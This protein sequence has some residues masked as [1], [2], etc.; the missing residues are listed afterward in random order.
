MKAIG[1]YVLLIRLLIIV[2]VSTPGLAQENNWQS[3]FNEKDLTGWQS[4]NGN[5][6]WE[7]RDGII[8]GTTVPGEPNGFLCTEKE[9]GD[10]VLE[11]EVSIDTLMNNSGVQF[12]SLSYPGYKNGRVHGYQV[13]INPLRE[14]S[15]L[16]A[17]YPQ[18]QWNGAIYEEGGNRGWLYP[19]GHLSPRAREA[20]KRDTRDDYQW[21]N[22]RI[23]AIG[24]S[25]RTWING[26][27]AAHLIDDKFH[28][29]FIGLQLHANNANDPQGSFSVRFRNIRIQ[30]GDLT[31]T[32][33]DNTF[34]VNLLP[35]N[36]SSQEEKNGF[37]L[38]WDGRST[39]GW[40]GPNQSNFPENAWSVDGG[41]L[42]VLKTSRTASIG[43]PYII[44]DQQ[45]GPFE[46]KFDFKISKGADSGVKYFVNESE[47]TNSETI[48]ALEYQVADDS[49]SGNIKNLSLGS[50][51]GIMESKKT[52]VAVKTIGEWNQALIKVHPDN[53]VEYWLNG[54]KILQFQR[55]SADFKA[56]VAKSKYKD[57][58]NFGMSTQGHI[59]LENN[60]SQVAYRS[61]K[62]KTLR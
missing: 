12:R 40:L 39:K 26:V 8:V 34:V 57:L 6:I 58:P 1:F 38:L 13:E 46:L 9:Y 37:V 55:G 11:F 29:G 22:Y 43:F 49:D 56:L 28:R 3:L 33:L 16:Y 15:K 17:V 62:I 59:L 4:L 2:F 54:N 52:T 10:F 45:Y 25:I 5:H 51:A 18:Q 53:L 14:K 27:P 23:E 44:T 61:L 42:K 47:M 19:G 41:E 48:S 50:L 20:F 7:V 35:N 21:D 60:G 32:F 24:T 36:L 31:P 30:T